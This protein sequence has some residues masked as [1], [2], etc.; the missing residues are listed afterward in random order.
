MVMVVTLLNL[1]IHEEDIKVYQY[2]EIDM[3][4]MNLKGKWSIKFPSFYDNLTLAV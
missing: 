2:F 4:S 1:L 3:L